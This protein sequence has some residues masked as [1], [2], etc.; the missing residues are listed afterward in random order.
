MDTG[1][2]DIERHISI[3]FTMQIV[4]VFQFHLTE[5]GVFKEEGFIGYHPSLRFFESNAI[6]LDSGTPL[7]SFLGLLWAQSWI[8]R[9]CERV[10]R[11][12]TWQEWQ[13]Y[14]LDEPWRT[15]CEQWPVLDDIEEITWWEKILLRLGWW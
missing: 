11:N 15:T 6:S 4:P 8:Q 14:L 13:A 10:G 12:L 5:F 1:P 3:I 7:F 9:A 2:D